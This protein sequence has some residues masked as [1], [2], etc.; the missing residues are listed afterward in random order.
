MSASDRA[1]L[2][3]GTLDMLVLKTLE[4]EPLHG[5]AIAQRIE[6]TSR[7]LLRVP[8]GSLYPSLHRLENRGWLAAAWRETD[9]GRA[10]RVYRLTAKGR[11]QL[12]REVADWQRLSG[13]I[14][15]ILGVERATP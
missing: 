15:W 8:Q 13:A 9:G 12:E 1:D 2:L 7:A 10:A 4:H 6:Q 5:Y 11:R 14:G 3:Q